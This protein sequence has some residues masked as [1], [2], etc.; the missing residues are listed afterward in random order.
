M[1]RVLVV[2]RNER[3]GGLI[4]GQLRENGYEAIDVRHGVEV[5]VE[6]RR[7]GS[8]RHPDGQPGSY[9]RSQDCPPHSPPRQ[10]QHHSH[11]SQFA[12]R[13]GAGSID[14]PAGPAVRPQELPDEAVYPGNAEEKVEPDPGGWHIDRKAHQPGGQRRNPQPHQLALDAG[15]TLQALEPTEQGGCGGRYPSGL[16]DSRTRSGAVC[17][18][19]GNMPLGTLRF[20]RAR[21]VSGGGLSRCCRHPQDRAVSRHI[22]HVCGGCGIGKNGGVAHE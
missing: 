16:I 6:L 15:R 1:V 12:T 3:I 22:Q 18:G 8:R 13:Q 17:Q 9:G 19:H 20:S 4:S 7:L 14:R 2:E 21:H 10:V 11:H 5:V